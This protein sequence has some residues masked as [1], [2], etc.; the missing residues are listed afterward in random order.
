MALAAV[1][2]IR[3]DINHGIHEN[4]GETQCRSSRAGHFLRHGHD[5]AH[6]GVSSNRR[7]SRL[8]AIARRATPEGGP[9]TPWAPR[10]DELVAIQLD[11]KLSACSLGRFVAPLGALLASRVAMTV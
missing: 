11:V 1:M 10:Q 4:Q 5:R 9:G 6:Y 3:P 8:S 2:E 7:S